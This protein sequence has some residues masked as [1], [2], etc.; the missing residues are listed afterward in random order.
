MLSLLRGFADDAAVSPKL[1][2]RRKVLKSK[3]M[4]WIGNG[5]DKLAKEDSA[6]LILLPKGQYQF[7]VR[8]LA[9]D[10]IGENRY[11]NAGQG[12]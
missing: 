1:A 5:Q 6:Y 3:Q 10:G 12:G 11:G 7:W 9:S 2:L 4:C 8:I